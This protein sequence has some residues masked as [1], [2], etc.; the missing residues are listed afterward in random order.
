MCETLVCIEAT[1]SMPQFQLAEQR[2][3]EKI[4]SIIF[5]YKILLNIY[6]V[7]VKYVFIIRMIVSILILRRGWEICYVILGNNTYIIL[8]KHLC[9]TYK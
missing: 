3:G 5:S 2:I 7:E 8:S 4:K 9:N 6:K 1:T